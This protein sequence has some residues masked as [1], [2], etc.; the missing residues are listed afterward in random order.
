MRR[1]GTLTLVTLSLLVLGALPAGDAVAQQKS[2]YFGLLLSQQLF[3]QAPQA[4]VP[5]E[6]EPRHRVVFE[7]KNVRIY[8]ALIPQGDLTLFHTHSFDNVFVVV[9][10]GKGTN[11]IPGKPPTEFAVP[12][13]VAGFSK[14]T[15]APY[16]HRVGNVGTTPLRFVVAEVLASSSSPG[17]PAVLDAVPGH[18]LVVENERVKVYRVSVD[19]KQSTGPRAR[20]LP[21]LRISIS[22]TTISVQE[23][24]K[25]AETL[26]TKTG[27]FRW[28]EGVTNQS[29]ENVGATPY[30]AIEIEW[31]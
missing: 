19:P 10:G 8:D 23:K 18:K 31:K 27:D 5:V 29:L 22:Q 14:A 28:H 21:W 16:T 11:E 15:N 20:T 7:N 24:E 26:E 3:A 12:T 2:R 1:L 30:E 9:S 6:Q 17:V 25:S 4:A 13:G